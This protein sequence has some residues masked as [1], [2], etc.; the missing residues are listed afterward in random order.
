MESHWSPRGYRTP[1][2]PRIRQ[3]T[4]SC[5]VGRYS[6][7]SILPSFG[8]KKKTRHP[9]SECSTSMSR[10]MPGCRAPAQGLENINNAL[11]PLMSTRLVGIMSDSYWLKPNSR[12]TR[13]MSG[14]K[15][16][17][18]KKKLKG[19][20]GILHGYSWRCG[21]CYLGF[22]LIYRLPVLEILIHCKIR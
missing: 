11:W 6:V 5:R 4:Y 12:P 8:K 20:W 22:R 10:R 16:P 13:S 1:A 17:G 19:S 21:V 7:D 2:S 18:A 3:G 15:T 14:K 9:L